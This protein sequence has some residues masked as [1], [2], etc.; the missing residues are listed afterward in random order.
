L[1]NEEV[2]VA[3]EKAEEK[4][5][6]EKTKEKEG[7]REEISKFEQDEFPRLCESP[8]LRLVCVR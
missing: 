8:L 6:Q 3:Q 7:K 1:A 4:M 5:E 2:A